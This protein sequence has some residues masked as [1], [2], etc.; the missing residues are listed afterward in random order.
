M[1]VHL[2]VSDCLSGNIAAANVFQAFDYATRMGAHIVSCSFTSTYSYGFYALAPAP[3]YY[4]AQT[5]AY[6]TAMKPMANKGILAVVAAGECAW[7]TV[8]LG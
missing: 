4:A 3:S 7:G 1:P 6:T 2:Q 8:C 5:A